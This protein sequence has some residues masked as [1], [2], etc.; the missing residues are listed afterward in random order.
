MWREHAFWTRV[1]LVESIAG[2][3]SAYMA[4]NQLMT[5]QVALGDAVKP[6]YG[7][8]E[9]SRLTL[10]LSTHVL[11]MADYIDAS[12][13]TDAARIAKQSVRLYANANDIAAL[14]GNANPGMLPEYQ[15]LWHRDIDHTQNQITARFANDWTNDLAAY[16]ESL[17][18]TRKMADTIATGIVK[19]WP[20]AGVTIASQR[21]PLGPAAVQYSGPM[22]S[23][24][25][26]DP[27]CTH[28][29]Y[30]SNLIR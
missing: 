13:G 27:P 19:L 23:L 24:P 28:C 6:F 5:N 9:G 11:A 12:K 29:P 26:P 3:P 7:P 1:M 17:Y 20:Q 4:T 30:D 21:L 18:G 10:L 8:A 14:Y 25:K 22:P 15:T 2:L 16:D